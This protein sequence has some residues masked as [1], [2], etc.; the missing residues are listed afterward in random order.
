MENYLYSSRMTIC[1]LN[2]FA[3]VKGKPSYLREL[4]VED[5]AK[6]SERLAIKTNNVNFELPNFSTNYLENSFVVTTIRLWQN[7]PA[8]IAN[9]SS[10]EV[11]K[12]KIY[13][14]FLEL[15]FQ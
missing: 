7:L 14:Y 5:E 2:F 11:F 13:D 3:R 9:A 12:T 8:E 1:T 4:F 15:E 6:R 10:L